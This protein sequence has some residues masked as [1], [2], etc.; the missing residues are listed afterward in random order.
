MRIAYK[1]REPS[2]TELKIEIFSRQLRVGASYVLRYRCTE[3]LHNA[4]T[5]IGK[6]DECDNNA[7]RVGRK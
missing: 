1:S 4:H 5:I 3:L 6:R 7:T 2:I